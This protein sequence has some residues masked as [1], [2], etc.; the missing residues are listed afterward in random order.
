MWL[1]VVETKRGTAALI[2]AP[3]LVQQ[4]ERSVVD[5]Q[6]LEILEIATEFYE[7]RIISISACTLH[8]LSQVGNPISRGV[9]AKSRF[10]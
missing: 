8:A 1:F 7:G 3:L 5:L 9:N 4:N 2:F 10:K 6:I